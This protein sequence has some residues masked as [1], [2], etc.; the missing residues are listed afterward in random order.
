M[1]MR[2]IFTVISTFLFFNSNFAMQNKSNGS[3]QNFKMIEYEIQDKIYI[4]ENLKKILNYLEKSIAK[5]DIKIEKYEKEL[6]EETLRHDKLVNEMLAMMKDL[7]NPNK[8]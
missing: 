6:N 4:L 3:N 2:F 1:K 7:E 8:P 5:S